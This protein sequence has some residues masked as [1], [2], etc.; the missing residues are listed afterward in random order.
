MMCLIDRRKQQGNV[1]SVAFQPLERYV[2][3]IYDCKVGRSSRSELGMF[4]YD[5]TSVDFEISSLPVEPYSYINR[6][7]G[8]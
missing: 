5:K 3:D 6:L 8:S 4:S 1:I 7:F 2:E